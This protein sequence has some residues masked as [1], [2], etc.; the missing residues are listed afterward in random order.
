MTILLSAILAL[1]PLTLTPGLL[2][3]YDVTPKIVVLLLGTAIALPLGLHRARSSS[4][5]LRIFGILRRDC[6]LILRQSLG[7]FP[8]MLWWKDIRT[9]NRWALERSIVPTGS[10]R[11]RA[12]L[13]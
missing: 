4:A 5:G 8:A 6:S 3:Y 11:W 7:N 12:P 2:F 9:I 1:L 10:C 13:A